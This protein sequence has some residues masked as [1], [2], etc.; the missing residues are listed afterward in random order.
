[1]RQDIPFNPN[2]KDGRCTEGLPINKSNWANTIDRGPFEA[3]QVGCGVSF[4]F[5]GVRIDP[6]TGQVI[7]GS[8]LASGSSSSG[9]SAVPVSVD[10]AD[11][12]RQMLLAALTIA[13]LLVLIF[14]PPLL[15]YTA[16]RREGTP[17]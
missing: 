7:G 17:R 13:A 6:D 1:V 12:R 10:S 16:C 9:A 3:Y 11:S 5:G 2:V 8:A 4:S 14:G 15:A